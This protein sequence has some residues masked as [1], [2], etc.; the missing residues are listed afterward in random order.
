M[1]KRFVL[2]SKVKIADVTDQYDVWASWGSD[3]E[4]GWDIERH[5]NFAKSGVIEPL[6]DS[7]PES[8]WGT[9]PLKLRDRRGVGLGHRMLVRKGDKRLI[10]TFLCKH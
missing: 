2:R 1:L 6:W 7:T 3:T 10:P 9:D 5:W 8:P 4:K